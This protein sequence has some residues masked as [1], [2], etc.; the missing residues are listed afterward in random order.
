MASASERRPGTPR[1]RRYPLGTGE[2]VPAD[3]GPFVPEAGGAP[4]PLTL[5]YR[6]DGPGPEAPQVMVIHALTGSAD[7]AGDWWAPLIG[8]GRAFD[9]D[10][11]G[12]LCANLV[13]GRYGSTGPTSIDP[14]TGRPWATAF[15][16]VTA[17]DEARA[18]WLL[19][20]A[21]GIEEFALVTGG[22]LGGMIALEVALARPR[23]VTRVAPIAAPAATGGLAIAWNH[24]QL[25]LI[26]RLGEDGLDLARQ[27][28]MT[29]YRSEADF[30]RRFGREHEVDG[31]FSV[32]SYLDHQGHKLVDRF[33]PDTY[34]VLVRA[35]DGHDIGRDRGGIPAALGRLADAGT[36]LTG[37]GI[38]GDILFG[39]SQV[40]A[41][42]DEAGAAGIDADYRE[43]R[44]TK[45]HDA[46]LTEWDQLTHLLSEALAL[47]VTAG[48][49]RAAA[50][51]S[52]STSPRTRWANRLAV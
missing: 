48:E 8:P 18:L 11:V 24:I 46:F 36:E 19:A 22:S 37:I 14:S 43:L 29:T 5:A 39:P 21:L 25:E 30:D 3:L 28:A 26:D 34:R 15:P 2:V 41:L 50:I 23:C 42:V 9:T 1:P 17:R 4:L 33:D 49:M 38:E 40:R 20:D 7:A 45:G 12:V 44:S 16:A 52:D 51:A 35:M 10:R 32:T 47:G 27:L 31:R 6:H 13:G